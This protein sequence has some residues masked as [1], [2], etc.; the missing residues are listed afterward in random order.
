MTGKIRACC[1]GFRFFSTQTHTQTSM[2]GSNPRLT[3]T[4]YAINQLDKSALTISEAEDEQDF[5][6]KADW[7]GFDEGESSW[8]PLA[9]I[10]DGA[11]QF[12]KSELRRSRLDRG[13]RS[14]LQK[15]YGITL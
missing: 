10:W 4:A 12:V 15:F 13:V 11:P 8:E 3:F 14:R 7:D 9:I 2:S 6:V 1:R 5:D